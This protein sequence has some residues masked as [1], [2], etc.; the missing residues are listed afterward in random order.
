MDGQRLDQE[1]GDAADQARQVFSFLANDWLKMEQRARQTS[2]SAFLV[3]F[4]WKDETSSKVE[5][6]FLSGTAVLVKLEKRCVLLARVS[7]REQEHEGLS[8]DDQVGVLSPYGEYNNGET[9]RLFR[10]AETASAHDEWQTFKEL[11]AF[12]ADY[13]AKL[14]LLES[15]V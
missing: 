9:V 14:R 13:A 8:L 15:S 11:R 1:T 10:I 7:N 5:V 4:D 2:L 12:E 6:S 3:V